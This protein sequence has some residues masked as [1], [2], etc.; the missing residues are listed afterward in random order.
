MVV[1]W[2]KGEG[3][4]ERRQK[5]G[6]GEGDTGRERERKVSAERASEMFTIPAA[7]LGEEG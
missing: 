5:K 6:S 3:D 4:G 7:V 1:D 2:L